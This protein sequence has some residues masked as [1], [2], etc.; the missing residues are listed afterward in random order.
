MEIIIT[1]D[2]EEVGRTA[3]TV[4]AE[5]LRR[6]DQPVL[7]LATGSSPV[8]A[9]RHLAHLV[10]AGEL[11]L[12]GVRGFALDEYVGL[13]AEHPQSYVS[14]IR[15]D[16]VEPLRMDPSLVHV[17]DGRAADVYAA[18]AAYDRSIAAAG[19]VDVQILGIGANGHIGFNEP[20][21]S[22]ASR[23][24]VKTLAERTRADN[25]RFFDRPEDVPMHC[26]TQ[27][28]GTILDAR[29]LV[30]VAAG[31]GKAAAIAAAVEGPV[32]GMCPA[33]ALQLHPDAIVVVDPAAA[34]QLALADYY[35]YVYAHKAAVGAGKA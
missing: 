7:G 15:R 18:A 3:A 2:A 23:T 26:I 21:S 22:L 12:G 16:V 25:A 11:D 6:A 34:S 29:Q 5:A 31:A 17:P 14:V 28:I 19:G 1:A 20:S 32:S 8:T 10:A 13:A 30:L 9:Y 33:S 35:R 24:R 4:I 27:G